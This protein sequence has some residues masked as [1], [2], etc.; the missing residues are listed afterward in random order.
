MPSRTKEAGIQGLRGA[1]QGYYHDRHRRRFRRGLDIRRGPLG[2]ERGERAHRADRGSGAGRTRRSNSR[3]SWWRP[4]RCASAW[5]S[6]ARSSP[7]FRGRRTILPQGAFAIDR[8]AVRRR[9]ARRAVADRDQRAGA[10]RQAFGRQRP[11]HAFQP[12]FAGHARR[13]HQDR[14]DRRRRRLRDA[15]RP[16]R[17]GADAR[18]RRHRGSV[19]QRGRRRRL[20][21]HHRDRRRERQGADG[22]A[23]RGR[24]PDQPAGRQFGDGRGDR[25]RRA[26]RSRWRAMSARCRCRCALRTTSAPLAT[27]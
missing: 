19:G 8:R 16:R 23:G 27:A 12:A 20:D 4:R 25:R 13:H 6:T 2:Q 1:G 21:D 24:A 11:R 17:R 26:R 10:A 15:G 18:R 5:N 7:K 9:H 22:R 14:R 3:R